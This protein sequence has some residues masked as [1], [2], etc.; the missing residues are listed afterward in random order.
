MILCRAYAHMAQGD[1]SDDPASQE[2]K[3]SE[4]WRKAEEHC[5][6]LT[7]K[8]PAYPEGWLGLARALIGEFA[9]WLLSVLPASCRLR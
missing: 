9:A 8:E 7:V 6:R 5:R 2:L 3:E 4:R 1:G